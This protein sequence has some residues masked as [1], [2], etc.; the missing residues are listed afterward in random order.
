MS[1]VFGEV[2]VRHVAEWILADKLPVPVRLQL[3]LHKFIWS[4]DTRGV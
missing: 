4:P 3:Q 1:P 2:E